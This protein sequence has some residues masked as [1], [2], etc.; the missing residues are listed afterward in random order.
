MIPYDVNVSFWSDG[1]QK[2][3]WFALP[4]GKSIEIDDEGHLVL[5]IGSVVVMQFML[6]NRLVETRLLVRHKDG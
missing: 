6:Q 3:R 4:Q 2:R 1:A 5:P